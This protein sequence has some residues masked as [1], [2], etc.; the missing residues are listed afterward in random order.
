MRI[1]SMNQFQFDAL[2]ELCPNPNRVGTPPGSTAFLNLRKEV[3]LHTVTLPRPPQ[4]F[5]PRRPVDKLTE[6]ELPPKLDDVAFTHRVFDRHELASPRG[7]GYPPAIRYVYVERE[8][9]R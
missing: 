8:P 5:I 3:E 9:S 2:F 6:P 1:E 7:K 4:W